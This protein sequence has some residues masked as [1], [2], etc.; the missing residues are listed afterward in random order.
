MTKFS[1]YEEQFQK[2]RETGMF[3]FGVKKDFRGKV[4]KETFFSVP[5]LIVNTF[6]YYQHNSETWIAFVTDE[7]RGVATM[8]KET[9]TEDDAVEYLIEIFENHNFSHYFHTVMENFEEKEKNIIE[10]LKAEYGYSETKAR[11]AMDY[12]LQVKII[13][14]EY[15]YFIE[16]GDYVPDKYASVYSGYTAKRISSETDLTILGAFNCMVYL[17]RK[18]EEALANLKAGLPIKDSSNEKPYTLYGFKPKGE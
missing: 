2:F 16:H 7:E 9:T 17:K 12:L 18:P 10:H 4:D 8:Q 6:G 1:D 14:F 11:K 13:A 3:Y 15:S 5:G